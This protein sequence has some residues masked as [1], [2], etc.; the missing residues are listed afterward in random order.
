[1]S[2]QRRRRDELDAV[3][4]TRLVPNLAQQILRILRHLHILLLA[5]NVQDESQLALGVRRRGDDEQTVE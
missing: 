4:Q 1:M 3:A 2:H 5:P